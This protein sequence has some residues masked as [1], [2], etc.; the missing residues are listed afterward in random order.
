MVTGEKKQQRILSLILWSGLV[1]KSMSQNPEIISR[2]CSGL[3][4]NEV[5]LYTSYHIPVTCK[6]VNC[7]IQSVSKNSDRMAMA[8]MVLT[9]ATVASLRS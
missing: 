7:V 5:N 3:G 9:L 8:C 1:E 2:Q 6:K 4:T